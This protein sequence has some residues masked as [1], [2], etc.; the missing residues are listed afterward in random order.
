METLSTF[1][2]AWQKS[3]ENPQ[4]AQNFVLGKLVQGYQTTDYGQEHRAEKVT[5]IEDFRTCFPIVGYKDLFPD[6][7]GDAR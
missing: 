2:S 3:L 4:K 1:L 6:R 7:E 5:T